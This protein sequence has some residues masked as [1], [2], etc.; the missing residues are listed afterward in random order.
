M[1][2]R[3]AALSRGRSRALVLLVSGA[4]AATTLVGCVPSLNVGTRV[5]VVNECGADVAVVLWGAP[6]AAPESST[7]G[8]ASRIR[9]GSSK[10]AV[11]DGDEPGEVSVNALLW[12]ATV[13]APSW[14]EQTE[15]KIDDLLQV[16]LPDGTK[17]RRLTIEGDLCP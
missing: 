7:T 3:G 16:T 17:A 5:E 11:V 6:A 15:F 10:T 4:V 14:G 1:P 8:E 12:V 13:G 9:D 2:G